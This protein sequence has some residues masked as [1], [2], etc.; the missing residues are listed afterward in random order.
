MKKVAVIQSNYIPWKGYFDIIHDVDLFVFHDDLQYTKN[1]WRN[2][3]KIKTARGVS[4]LTIP[5]G[6]R[7]DRLICEVELHDVSWQKNH[8]AIIMQ[9]YSKAPFFRQYRDF[10]EQVYLKA[11]WNNLSELNQYL[12][13]TISK[14]FLGIKADFNDSRDFHA[15]GHKLDRLIDL[16]VKVNAELYVS[17]PAAKDYIEENKFKEVEIELVFK[18]YSNYP[19]YPQLFP[20]FEHAVSILDVLFNCGAAAPDYI[21]GWRAPK[22][23]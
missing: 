10:F 12:I 14:E 21:W 8:W 19:E 11:K 5:V 23:E 7:E 9:S 20:P 4:W 15:E 13:K 3:N 18:D 1:D 2:R 22:P 16:L 17:G 6:T